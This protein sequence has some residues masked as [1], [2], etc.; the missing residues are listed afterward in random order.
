M[1]TGRLE[2]ASLF[3][4]IVGGL[5]HTSKPGMTYDDYETLLVSSPGPCVLHVQMN[6]PSKS[7]AMN[8]KFW[9]EFRECFARIAQDADTRAVVIS[10]VGEVQKLS[11]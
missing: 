11:R 2:S 9:T 4:L 3:N 1:S 8:A 6:R 10:G 7:N 5:R